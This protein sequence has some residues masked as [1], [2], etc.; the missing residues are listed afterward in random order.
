MIGLDNFRQQLEKLEAAGIPLSV[1]QERRLLQAIGDCQANF[2]HTEEAL[3]TSKGGEGGSLLDS[4]ESGYI[5]SLT[6]TIR[7]AANEIMTDEQAKLAR[8]FSL[9]CMTFIV[10]DPRV[11]DLPDLGQGT[12]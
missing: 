2:I 5:R 1:E 4:F 8:F 7:E 3:M 11:D 9:H 12:R 6:Q 10:D